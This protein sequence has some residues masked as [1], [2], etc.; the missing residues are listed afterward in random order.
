VP[1]STGAGRMLSLIRGGHAA[2]RSE[3]ALQTGLSRSTIAERVRALLTHELVYEAGGSTSTGGRPANM[4]A[5]NR[6][7]GVVLAADLGATLCRLA[8]TD[9]SGAL[10]AERAV[11]IDITRSLRHVLGLVRE[12]FTELLDAAGCASAEVWGVGV[13]IPGRATRG[14]PPAP[15]AAPA[16]D[17]LAISRWFSAL[18]DAPV[19][20]DVDLNVMAL[21]ESGTHWRDVEHLLYVK[22]GD[23]I[24][25]SIVAGHRIHRGAQGIAGDIGHIRLAGRDDVVCRCGNVGC[26]EAV[27]GGRALAAT[28][29]AAGLPARTGRD[30]VRLVGAGEPLALQ[31]VRDAGRALGEVLAGAVSFF[32]PGAI[33][34]GGELSGAHVQ[35]LAGVREVAF[36]RSLPMAT[37]NLRMG[38]GE[39]GERAGVI[40]AAVMV[41]EHLLAPETVDRVLITRRRAPR[42][43][44]PRSSA[45]R[46]PSSAPLP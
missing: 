16:W 33:V 31:A 3:L 38:H 22:V 30:V 35:L 27:A 40:G 20:V 26:L 36:E 28:L 14:D 8:L 6:G 4:L 45:P 29:A 10:L 34:I 13:G 23:G 15:A 18:Y 39:L 43:R 21:G 11:Y 32:N 24:G 46:A 44:A 12:R 37:R 41:I 25:C 2:T 17:R 5:F 19:L 9:L 7:A 42:A 1:A